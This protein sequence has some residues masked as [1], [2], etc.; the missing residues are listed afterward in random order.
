[1]A[2]FK[3]LL[4]WSSIPNSLALVASLIAFRS[5]A[6]ESFWSS[7][8][9]DVSAGQAFG[10][11]EHAGPGF[12]DSAAKRRPTRN[13]DSGQTRA[14]ATKA[15]AGEKSAQRAKSSDSKSRS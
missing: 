15:P 2:K 11:E 9:S 5:G 1:M 12:G 10:E 3:C 6:V 4:R 8:D 7:S 14:G 13:N